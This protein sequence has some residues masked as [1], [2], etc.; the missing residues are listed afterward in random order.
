MCPKEAQFI[1]MLAKNNVSFFINF[2]QPQTP[3]QRQCI[4]LFVSRI[5]YDNVL[6]PLKNNM[7]NNCIACHHC[8]NPIY[9]AYKYYKIFVKQCS[10]TNAT[11]LTV[12]LESPLLKGYQSFLKYNPY[13]FDKYSISF[14]NNSLVKYPATRVYKVVKKLLI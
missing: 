14:K 13:Q 11:F 9:F 5:V 10:L 7:T 4:F 2:C 6:H 8:S 1:D 12:V 3:W